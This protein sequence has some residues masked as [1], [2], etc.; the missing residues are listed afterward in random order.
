[1]I[2]VLIDYV[3]PI[4]YDSLVTLI[5]VL[6]ILFIFRI[7]DSGIRI[8][9]LFLPLIK[10][11]LVVAERLKP[12]GDIGEIPKAYSGLRIPN[13]NNLFGWF[14]KIEKQQKL[15]SADINYFILLLVGLAILLLLMIRWFNLYLLYRRLAYEDKVSRDEIPLVYRII[16]NFAHKLSIKP[17]DVSLTHRPYYSP[18]VVGI[19]YCTI[20]IYPNILEV[21][22]QEEKEILLHH[23]LSHIKRRDNLIGWIAMILRDFMFFNPFAYIAYYLIRVEQDSGSD[24]LMISHSQKPGKE[25]A[26]IL[27]NA[28]KKLGELGGKR[29]EPDGASGFV[30]IAGRFFA[31]FRLRNRVRSIVANDGK[32]IRMRVFPRIMVYILFFLVLVLQI[33]IV[34]DIGQ[35][36][37]YLR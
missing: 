22:K 32:R 30:G 28:V 36:N 25:I 24:K 16:E 12:Y 14:E 17:P 35:Y 15:F 2:P 5:T 31:H 1:L 34:I 8:L 21:L 7:K 13:P 33:L 3:I 23:E 20:V 29:P 37:L 11:F 18:F 10:P 6:L 4:I 26:I 19:R 27:L 9:F